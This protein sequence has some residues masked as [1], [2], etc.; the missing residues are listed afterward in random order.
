MAKSERAKAFTKL[1]GLTYDIEEV[2]AAHANDS[3]EEKQ[4]F[5]NKLDW[6]V[7][8]GLVDNI[9]ER[10]DLY[11]ESLVTIANELGVELSSVDVILDGIEDSSFED[12]TTTEMP[13]TEVPT[14]EAPTIED[15]TTEEPATTAAPTTDEP[16]T[17]EE[18]IDEEVDE[19]LGDE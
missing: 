7:P 1:T 15:P 5:F 12:E 14:T 11:K 16:T 4:K 18:P 17:T 10:K 9:N 19:D 3:Q 6:I 8:C 2:I 13:T